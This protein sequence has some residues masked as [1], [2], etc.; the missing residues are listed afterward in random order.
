MKMHDDHLQ[1]LSLGARIASRLGKEV[2]HI[3][4]MRRRTADANE[5]LAEESDLRS[6]FERTCKV[7]VRKLSSIAKQRLSIKAHLPH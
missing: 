4:F 6:L 2:T 7:R 3:V 5:Q 1:V